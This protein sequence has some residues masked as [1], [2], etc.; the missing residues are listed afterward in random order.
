LSFLKATFVL[1]LFGHSMAVI[2]DVYADI[3]S[4]ANAKDDEVGGDGRSFG[5]VV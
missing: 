3:A 2:S 4:A 5:G 1:F